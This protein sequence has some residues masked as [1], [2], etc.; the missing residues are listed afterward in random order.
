M[1]MSNLG[2]IQSRQR[3]ACPAVRSQLSGMSLIDQ[4]RSEQL[5]VACLFAGCR[6]GAG[7]EIQIPTIAMSS[8]CGPDQTVTETQGLDC[9]SRS[10]PEPSTV[11]EGCTFLKRWPKYLK[12]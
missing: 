1:P 11:L 12:L 5:L 4:R 7:S 6:T 3:D 2:R 10:I 8:D 9:Q